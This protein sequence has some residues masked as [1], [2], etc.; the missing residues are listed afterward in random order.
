M[1]E[2]R[3]FPPMKKTKSSSKSQP[4]SKAESQKKSQAQS[5]IGDYIDA[6]KWSLHSDNQQE[7]DAVLTLSFV[8]SNIP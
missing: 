6:P 4:K 2:K 5:Q 8:L 1:K 7:F 3:F